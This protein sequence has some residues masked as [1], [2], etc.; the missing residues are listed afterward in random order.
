MRGTRR[1]KRERDK[2]KEERKK[3][4]HDYGKSST[5]GPKPF[6]D[7]RFSFCHFLDPAASFPLVSQSRQRT[8]AALFFFFFFFFRACSPFPIIYCSKCSI[9]WFNYHYISPRCCTGAIQE[10]RKKLSN[11]F[12]FPII[13]RRPWIKNDF[14][15]PLVGGWANPVVCF[16]GLEI[17]RR[18]TKMGG[19]GGKGKSEGLAWVFLDWRRRRVRR[20]S[21]RRGEPAASSQGRGLRSLKQWPWIMITIIPKDCRVFHSYVSWRR[22]ARWVV[23]RYADH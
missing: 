8:F 12:F 15:A 2:W 22:P 10:E 16:N 13:R 18:R 4:T 5:L 9:P 6:P 23:P 21:C 14:G 19:G 17:M 11:L 1:V 20:L 3:I 7:T